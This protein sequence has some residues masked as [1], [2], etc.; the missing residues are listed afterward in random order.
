MTLIVELH[1][2]I[3]AWWLAICMLPSTAWLTKAELDGAIE[4][5]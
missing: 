5:V 1:R 4:E 2:W 3:W